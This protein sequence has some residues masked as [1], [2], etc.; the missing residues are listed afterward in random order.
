MHRPLA[1]VLVVALFAACTSEGGAPPA[2]PGPGPTV[3]PTSSP[4]PQPLVLDVVTD[5]DQT[6]GATPLPN[7]YL[8]GMRLA[9]SQINTGRGVGGR[10]VELAVHDHSVERGSATG[11]VRDLLGGDPTVI[12]YVG[13]GTTLS[14]L[15]AEFAETGTPVVLLGGDLYTNRGLFPQ[16]FQTT[17]PWEW[18]ANVIAR[19]VVTDREAEDV[20]FLGSGPEARSARGALRDALEYW[21]GDLDAGFDDR[22]RDPGTGLAR[23][24]RRAGRADWV[25]V[26]G[27]SLD[28]LELTNALEEG[29]SIDRTSDP[30]DRPGIS[31]PSSLLVPSERLAHPEPGTTACMTYTW[32]GW[33]EPIPRVGKFRAKFQAFSGRLPTGLE[34][35]GYDAVRTV[36]AALRGTGGEGGATLTGALEEEI[37][38]RTFSGFPIDLG[39]DDHLFAPRDEL[40]LFAVPGPQDELDPWLGEGSPAW[41]PLMRTFTYDGMRTSVLNQDRRVFFPFW[42]ENLPGPKYWRSRYGITTRSGQDPLH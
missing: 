33:A 27:D 6:L 38:E 7:S 17:I 23:A 5:V 25:V 39:P 4:G 1:P 19:Y 30:K 29:A 22:S 15:R 12:L 16:V 40:G 8:D 31:G 9:V 37:G 20:V 3:S 13:P 32:S 36:V 42:N 26:F 11:L 2:S 28:A 34:Q 18:Q 10:P 14:P 35:E 41:M 21:G 24:F